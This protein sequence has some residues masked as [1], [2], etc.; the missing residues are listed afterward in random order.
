MPVEGPPWDNDLYGVS[1]TSWHTDVT[2]GTSKEGL[3]KLRCRVPGD[4]VTRSCVHGTGRSRGP[5][6]VGR[7]GG[8]MLDPE[9]TWA[10]VTPGPVDRGLGSVTKD[11]WGPVHPTSLSKI[12]YR[13]WKT[14]VGRDPDRV[15]GVCSETSGIFPLWVV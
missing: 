2:T 13:V 10:S 11:T 5:W 7:G 9:H 14:P 1:L 4:F 12:E 15:V 6:S 8:G 3:L